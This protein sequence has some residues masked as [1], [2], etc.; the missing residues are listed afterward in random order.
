MK[1]LFF[2]FPLF[3]FFLVGVELRFRFSFDHGPGAR[4]FLG[5]DC[6]EFTVSSHHRHTPNCRTGVHIGDREVEYRYNEF[7]Q[8]E[9]AFADLEKSP[10]VLVVGDS[11]AEGWGLAA[12]E[13]VSR[14]LEKR[15]GGQFTFVNAGLR[16]SGPVFQAVHL[17]AQIDAYRPVMILWL[18]TEKDYGYDQF[19]DALASERD[20]DGFPT[21]FSLAD[22]SAPTRAARFLQRKLPF[23]SYALQYFSQPFRADRINEIRARANPRLFQPCR[24]VDRFF[25]LAGKI[26]VLPV[27]MPIGP[28]Y[29]FSDDLK[30]FP[31]T[32]EC[33][34]RRSRLRP[35]DTR[36]EFSRSGEMH[37][38]D[39]HFSPR[40]ASAFA[41]LLFPKLAAELTTRKGPR[42]ISP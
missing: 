16:L 27:L 30:H 22:I 23:R 1:Y 24:G 15:F 25:A 41:D 8:R 7:G 4:Q 29:I 19:A 32:W 26:K 18:L 12:E 35:L 5:P 6:M 37:S 20:A 39:S 40:G 2:F 17:R 33:V 11:N 42:P 31:Q 21:A 14:Q 10:R 36:P 34:S 9:R 38:G 3:L 28:N 13:T